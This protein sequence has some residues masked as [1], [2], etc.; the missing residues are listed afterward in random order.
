VEREG[1]GVED[2]PTARHQGEATEQADPAILN[3]PFF[4]S[5]SGNTPRNRGRLVS[6]WWCGGEGYG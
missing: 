4:L 2:C 3:P 5:L 6:G 1:G